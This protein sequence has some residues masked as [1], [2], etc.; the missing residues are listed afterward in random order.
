MFNHLRRGVLPVLASMFAGVLMVAT[1]FA[2]ETT[3]PAN[4]TL[5]A[6][7][8]QSQ[9]KLPPVLRVIPQRT[10]GLEPGKSV[11]WT[12]RD[13]IL[14]ALENN[15]DFEIERSSV[16]QAGFDVISAEG[17]YD[18]VSTQGTAFT[19]T[20]QPNTRPFSGAEGSPS[21]TSK[22]INFNFGHR[23]LIYRS[24]GDYA[25]NFNNTRQSNNFSLFTSQYNPQLNFTINQP[26]WRNFKIDRNRYQIQLAKKRLDLSDATFRQRA[27]EI[28][29][30]VQTAYWNLALAIKDEEIQRDAV[31]LAETQLNNNQRQV[32]VGTKAPIDVVESATVMESRRQQVYQAMNQIAMAENTLKNLTANGPNDDLWKSQIIPVE[33]FEAAPV[34]L[35]LDDAIK[36]AMDNRP[37][38]KQ[39]NLQKQINDTDVHFLR[40]QTKPQIDLNFGY[41]TFG[42]GGN[43]LNTTQT[44]SNCP[45]GFAVV[46]ENGVSNCLGAFNLVQDPVTKDIIRYEPGLTRIP[47]QPIIT[48][49]PSVASNF[50]GGYFTGLRNLFSNDFRQWTVGV[51]VTLPWRNR[52][53]KANLGRALE[54][55]RQIDLQAR[56]SMQNI[57]VEVR[58]AVQTVETAK[59]RIE[60]SRAQTEY[61]RQQL[62]GEQKRFQAGLSTTFF[63]LQ[64]QNDLSIARGSE[65]RALADYNIAVA[66]LQ[67]VI[68]T[69][70]SSNSVE[71]KSEATTQTGDKKW[72]DIK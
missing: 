55:G 60:A 71:I 9:D 15:P 48:T 66:E 36:L 28:I 53:A 6:A 46:V 72:A 62:E 59:M 31:K 3:P 14:A 4:P 17:A 32:E 68:S 7:Q 2:Q 22:N 61:A 43:A 57:E 40:N 11:R 19:S 45:L 39:F 47:Y 65:L 27:I 54:S 24:G 21:L 42:V 16:R 5:P 20:S 69:T 50:V 13:A 38:L 41:T 67:R 56:R 52:T 12:L 49:S 8:T 37:E 34:A 70:L 44:R 58:N 23:G 30:R 18:P 10:V 1:A 64:R 35:P 51:S 26:L 29:S 25:I 63:V 33:S